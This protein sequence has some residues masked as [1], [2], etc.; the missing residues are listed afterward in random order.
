VTPAVPARLASAL[1]AGPRSVGRR[2]VARTERRVNAVHRPGP[3]TAS[4]RAT[5]LHRTLLVADLH[6]DS[7]LWGR[8]LLVRGDRGHVDV[9]RLIE[10]GVALQAMAA[11]TKVPRKLNL[12]RND[13][14]SDDI[15][16]VA[17][18]LGW[19]L[20][21]LRSLLARAL[22]LARE[23]DRLAAASGGRFTV[24]RTAVE[25]AGH[26]ERHRSGAVVTAGLL[27]IEGAQALDGDPANVDRLVDAGYRM[28]SPAHFYDTRFGGSAH[29]VAKG[30]LTAVGREMVLRMEARS[31]LVDVS[32]ASV[33]TID[34]VLSI[35]ARP[36]VAS[37]GGVV[38]SCPGLRNL[39]DD[40]LRA[41]AATGGLVGIG[42]W[43]TAI[44][45][46]DAAAI[47]RAI[48]HAAGVVGIEHVALGSDFDGA[49]PTPFD[50]TGM[51]LITEAL[52]ADG[53]AD[54]DIAAVMGGN[55]FR[56][57]AETLPAV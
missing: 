3:Y 8:D 48:G 32:H 20:A 36:V 31:M 6:A 43:P 23:A 15:L 16:L 53:F 38:G 9:P 39:S 56:L 18:A 40:H 25:L 5:E 13:G 46:D 50:A 44:C 45:G 10:G 26:L 54:A 22:F 21:T 29:G 2:L 7:L 51:V 35:A 1:L 19:P 52:L 34:D 24:I 37:H 30:G 41:L 55:V 11:S 57:L 14:R 27:T 28:M 17:I 12:D 49:V 42:F 47:A 33:A 4:A